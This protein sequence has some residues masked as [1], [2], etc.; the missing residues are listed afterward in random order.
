MKVR[1]LVA[2]KLLVAVGVLVFL[3]FSIDLSHFWA[4]ITSIPWYVFLIGCGIVVV[5]AVLLAIRWSSIAAFFARVNLPL[6]DSLAATLISFFFSQGLPASVGGDAVRIWLLKEH[7]DGARVRDGIKAVLVDRFWGFLTLLFLGCVGLACLAISQGNISVWIV[8]IG[9]AAAGVVAVLIALVSWPKGLLDWLHRVA[10]S[11]S[12]TLHRVVDSLT[13]LKADFDS[14]SRSPSRFAATFT[15]S[16]IVH[17]LTLSLAVLFVIAV[18]KAL[19]W[20]SVSLAQFLA[21]IPP[22]L[23]VG[24][25]PI[26]IAGWGVREG[27]M[28]VSLGLVGVSI[29]QAVA[30]SLFIGLTVLLV[31][32]LGGL[33]WLFSAMR[34]APHELVSADPSGAH[35]S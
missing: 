7:S 31:S 25:L 3:A 23:L 33:I 1:F 30:I 29:E 28:V 35:S 20:H 26:S 12:P 21:A 34:Q 32:L 24:Y 16:L 10:R 6:A 5:Q 4:L 18:P 19:D 8:P 17:L 15:L 27:A 9:I 13:R 11:A 22:A 2:I 14:Y